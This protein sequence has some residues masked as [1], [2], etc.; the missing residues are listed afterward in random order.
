VTDNRE[1]RDELARVLGWKQHPEIPRVW[2]GPAQTFDDEGTA[3]HPI[4]NTLDAAAACLPEGWTWWKVAGAWLS[5]VPG[6]ADEGKAVEVPDTGDE[7][8]DR[9]AL[10]LAAHKAKESRRGG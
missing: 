8:A 4:P 2:W 3:T 6:K 9:F 1:L 5:C 10:A 7:I